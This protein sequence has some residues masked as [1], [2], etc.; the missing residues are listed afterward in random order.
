MDFLVNNV[1]R[2]SLEDAVKTLTPS[3]VGAVRNHTKF[4]DSSITVMKFWQDVASSGGDPYPSPKESAWLAEYQIRMSSGKVITVGTLEMTGFAKKALTKWVDDTAGFRFELTYPGGDVKIVRHSVIPLPEKLDK[5]PGFVR[6]VSFIAGLFHIDKGILKMVMN[7]SLM[8]KVDF[9]ALYLPGV[10]ELYGLLEKMLEKEG[11][12]KR[13]ASTKKGD[14]FIELITDFL[15]RI[16]I[17]DYTAVHMTIIYSCLRKRGIVVTNEGVKTPDSQERYLSLDK[18]TEIAPRSMEI[19][20][21]QKREPLLSLVGPMPVGYIA[22]KSHGT[23]ESACA[24]FVSGTSLRGSPDGGTTRLFSGMGFTGIPPPLIR[25]VLTIVGVATGIDFSKLDMPKFAKAVTYQYNGELFD[26]SPSK[27]VI[28]RVAPVPDDMKIEVIDNQRGVQIAGASPFMI[29][30]LAETLT[31]VGI[32]VRFLLPAMEWAKV[33]AAYRKYL[34]KALSRYATVIYYVASVL[35]LNIV[36]VEKHWDELKDTLSL[37]NYRAVVVGRHLPT[38]G[39]KHYSFRPPYDFYSVSATMPLLKFGE[40]T[41]VE[42]VGAHAFYDAV[43][44]ANRVVTSFW[45]APVPHKNLL[46]SNMLRGPAVDLLTREG[47]HHEW[48]VVD[49]EVAELAVKNSDEF[50]N[51]FTKSEFVS[52]ANSETSYF[53]FGRGT[54][55]TQ[56]PQAPGVLISNSSLTA[57]VSVTSLPFDEPVEDALG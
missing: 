9:E 8:E 57:P 35:Q 33:P 14:Q 20:R 18:K 56:R 46:L 34:T 52:T 1:V 40:R 49:L 23:L 42:H 2:Q 29:P 6:V 16:S 13:D 28:K 48:Q 15:S 12:V 55:D 36:S 37:R 50:V 47:G 43:S 3:E 26:F 5:R 19:L 39:Y 53:A 32:G 30:L 24:A 22:P 45:L 44:M 41:F 38:A 25:E 27:G 17:D 21:Q 7:P 10:S 54:A 51:N 4:S 31:N 11:C